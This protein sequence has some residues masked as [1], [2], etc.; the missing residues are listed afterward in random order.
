M[1]LGLRKNWK[2]KKKK[3]LASIDFGDT[4][5]EIKLILFLKQFAIYGTDHSNSI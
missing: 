1:T 3:Y 5:M 4:D 2:Q